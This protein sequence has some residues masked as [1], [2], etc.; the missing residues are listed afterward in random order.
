MER[1][2]N[3]LAGLS[4][5]WVVCQKIPI[6]KFMIVS[7]SNT[8]VH[9]VSLHGYY[10]QSEPPPPS[11]THPVRLEIRGDDKG[12]WKLQMLRLASVLPA[13][14]LAEIANKPP[15]LSPPTHKKR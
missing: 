8:S 3:H 15:S 9:R 2:Y 12:K 11:L 7:F 10:K 6:I 1:E 14:R 13:L 4:R 5:S